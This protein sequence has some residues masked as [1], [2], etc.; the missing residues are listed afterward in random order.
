MESMIA[1]GREGTMVALIMVERDSRENRGVEVRA[2]FAGRDTVHIINFG[3]AGSLVTFRFQ[4][5]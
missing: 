3:H 1:I 5:N 2:H 4:F